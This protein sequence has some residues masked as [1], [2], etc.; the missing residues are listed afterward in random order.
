MVKAIQITQFLWQCYPHINFTVGCLF[1]C[2]FDCLFACH[3]FSMDHGSAKI[4]SKLHKT[5][6]ICKFW[7]PE[8]LLSW[9][10]VSPG[11][12]GVRLVLGLVWLCFFLIYLAR[13]CNNLIYI[14]LTNI[15][16]LSSSDNTVLVT[17][18]WWKMTTVKYCK[19]CQ[20]CGKFE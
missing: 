3:V 11:M 17:T 18:S 12:V 4:K 15:M 5:F 1:D 14:W 9:E 19:P 8:L 10:Q 7:S 16:Y 20:W 2:P 13:T 6:S